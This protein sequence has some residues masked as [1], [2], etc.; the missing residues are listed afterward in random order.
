MQKNTEKSSGALHITPPEEGRQRNKKYWS[1]KS[2]VVLSVHE[3]AL[4]SIRQ[5][6]YDLGMKIK[7]FQTDFYKND[8]LVAEINRSTS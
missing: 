1:K 7:R 6:F 8:L 4:E 3:C 5:F 2:K